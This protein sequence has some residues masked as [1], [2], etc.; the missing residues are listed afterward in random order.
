MTGELLIFIIYFTFLF[1]L[2]AL[3][4]LLE[5]DSKHGDAHSV[6]LAF[7]KEIRSKKKWL[8]EKVCVSFVHCYNDNNNDN[9]R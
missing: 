4:W 2:E 5:N 8:V 6:F 1:V 3:V 7:C 9:N